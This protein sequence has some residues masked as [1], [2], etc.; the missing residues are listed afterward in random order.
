MF[1]C[2]LIQQTQ[3]L[4][5]ETSD[6]NDTRNVCNVELIRICLIN[7]NI[8][9][10]IRMRMFGLALLL[11]VSAS[12]I[13]NITGFF[14]W[15]ANFHLEWNRWDFNLLGKQCILLY[16]LL[17]FHFSW[18]CWA[19]LH[20]NGS[21]LE[22]LGQFWL[23][24]PAERWYLDCI[25]IISFFWIVTVPLVITFSSYAVPDFDELSFKCHD[26]C[27]A[28]LC[29]EWVDSNKDWRLWSF[30]YCGGWY[31]NLLACILWI[32]SSRPYYAWTFP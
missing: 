31:H 19:S 17:R 16:G 7:L 4:F 23:L 9:R 21:L 18:S 28:A 2:S 32:F 11:K 29:F 12:K 22:V 5:S 15:F 20:K 24:L 8:C 10:V 25:L 30:W 3:K 14:I 27:N 6:P 1:P 26:S 13:R